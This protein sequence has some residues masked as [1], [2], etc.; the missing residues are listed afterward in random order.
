MNSKLF[1]TSVFFI[2]FVHGLYYGMWVEMSPYVDLCAALALSLGI[3]FW[4]HRDMRLRHY[5]PAFDSRTFLFIR[6]AP[7]RALLSVPYARPQGAL[8]YSWLRRFSR[9]R[10]RSRCLRGNDRYRLLKLRGP[11][12][13]RA[14]QRR[15]RKPPARMFHQGCGNCCRSRN[16]LF[17]FR[18]RNFNPNVGSIGDEGVDAGA[19][20]FA[21]LV[22]VV[23]GVEGHGFAGGVQVGE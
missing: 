3:V 7:G 19:D 8:A 18:R 15:P 10:S 13:P 4:L 20:E 14:R 6:V 2:G 1:W 5:H 9:G 12:P 21:H 22:W 23:D 11:F 17:A 16:A